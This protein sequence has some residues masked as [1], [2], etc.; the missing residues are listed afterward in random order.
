MTKFKW[1]SV[2]DDLP[3]KEDYPNGNIVIVTGIEDGDRYYYYSE[4]W[5]HGKYGEIFGCPGWSKMNVTHWA[6]IPKLK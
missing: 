4:I 3:R 2:N 6:P 1:I 5:P